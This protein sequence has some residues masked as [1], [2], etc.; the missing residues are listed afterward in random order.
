VFLHDRVGFGLERVDLGFLGLR[1][2][3]IGRVDASVVDGVILDGDK[4]YPLPALA[5]GGFRG[6]FQL[7]SDK[8]VQQG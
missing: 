7:L 1:G 5:A 6:G 2:F 4:L 8:A 3:A